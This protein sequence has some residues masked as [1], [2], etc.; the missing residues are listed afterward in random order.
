MN[1]TTNQDQDQDQDQDRE[2]FVARL[3]RAFPD[4]QPVSAAQVRDWM[5]MLFDTQ[6]MLAARLPAKRK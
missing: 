2:E 4:S 6:V 3:E 5:L 1:E